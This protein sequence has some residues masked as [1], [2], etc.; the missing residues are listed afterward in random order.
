MIIIKSKDAGLE[1][2]ILKILER[3]QIHAEQF[4]FSSQYQFAFPG[5]TIDGKSQQAVRNGMPVALTKTEFNLLLFLASHAGRAVSKED[6]LAAVW[7]RDSEDTL[8]VVAN[9]ISNLRGKIGGRENGGKY[10]RTVRGGYMFAGE[11]S[12]A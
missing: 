3:E 12:P 10:I 8:K 5:L 9:T 4:S 2:K 11:K 1:E 6:L 7:G